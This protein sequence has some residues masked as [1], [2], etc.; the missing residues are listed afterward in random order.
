MS[1]WISFI[2][3]ALPV[4]FLLRYFT[5]KNLHSNS[6]KVLFSTFFRGLFI[7]VPVMIINAFISKYRPVLND[8][9]SSAFFT[10]F[11]Q[12][13]LLEEYFKFRVL[14]KYNVQKEHLK[15]PM[16]GIV[17]GVAVSLGFALIENVFY[18]IDGGV[19][20]AV[21][22]ALTSVPAHASF[23]AIMGFFVG[24]AKFN[25]G[26]GYSAYLG[27]FIAIM[28]HG[29]YNLPIL[30]QSSIDSLGLS[31]KYESVTMY[32][33]VFFLLNFLFT[34]LW[35]RSLAKRLRKSQDED[36]D[37]IFIEL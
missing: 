6:K 1:L 10:A 31:D 21:L 28:L 20:T 35:A 3:A 30:Y 9:F 26:R 7:V 27:L 12:A 37:Q 33:L 18:V 14:I 29:L 22:R 25:K 11:I 17:Y 34:V 32:L 24:Q 5:K 8:P 4:I 2:G 23:G 36:S 19:R 13:G 16:D 15:E